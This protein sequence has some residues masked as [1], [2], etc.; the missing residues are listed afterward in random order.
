MKTPEWSPPAQ[1]GNA[2]FI[3]AARPGRALVVVLPGAYGTPDDV[4]EQGLA[5]MLAV[6]HPS[7]NLLALPVDP[8][9][10]TQGVALDRLIAE[11]APWCELFGPVWLV[12]ISLGALLVLAYLAEK[13]EGVRGAVALTP[14]LGSR[15][16]EQD[17][18]RAGG[19]AAWAGN[20]RPDWDARHLEERVWHWLA[21]GG[22]Q[23]VPV[24]LG[25]A[26]S[27]RFHSSQQLA[28]GCWPAERCF[29]VAG[30]HDWAAWR[31]LWGA[32]LDRV[33]SLD[34]ETR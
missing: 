24:M 13:G 22:A 16:L 15:A 33:Q 10:V 7:A 32:W 20:Q 27:D 1:P 5:E 25:L 31:A 2:L 3:P 29:S 11:L 34:E 18:R 23:R 17:I 19:P 9:A 8:L 12:G 28:S 4:V 30:G 14:Y 26:E 6:R 21:G